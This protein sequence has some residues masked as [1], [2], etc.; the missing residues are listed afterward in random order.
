M[1]R[2]WGLLELEEVLLRSSEA[3]TEKVD[4]EQGMADNCKSCYVIVLI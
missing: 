4:I 3:F 2:F 1:R